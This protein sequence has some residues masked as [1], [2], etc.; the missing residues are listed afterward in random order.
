MRS[1]SLRFLRAI[2]GSAGQPQGRVLR[3]SVPGCTRGCHLWA[4]P[5]GLAAMS[6]GRTG[7][8]GKRSFQGQEAGWAGGEVCL[9]LARAVF[10]ALDFEK[11]RLF[12]ITIG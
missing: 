10:R 7:L 5:S 6:P 2:G 4:G 9:P 3:R 8:T 1:P 11:R 12:G